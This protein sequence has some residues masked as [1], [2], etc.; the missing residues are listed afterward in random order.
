MKYLLLQPVEQFKNSWSDGLNWRSKGASVAHRMSSGRSEGPKMGEEG[1]AIF[2]HVAFPLLSLE[3]TLRNIPEYTSGDIPAHLSTASQEG[4]HGLKKIWDLMHVG[5][6]FS[7]PTTAFTEL[8]ELTCCTFPC[9]C[10]M[11]NLFT[12][13]PLRWRNYSFYN[14][15]V[16]W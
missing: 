16:C 10:A 14:P 8:D 11:T 3:A 6:I 12:T 9:L 13:D 1:S 2:L 4:S 7:L 15:G 5:N